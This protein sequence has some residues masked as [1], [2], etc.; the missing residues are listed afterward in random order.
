M[1]GISKIELE[2]STVKLEVNRQ[3][4]QYHLREL[5]QEFI[6]WQIQNRLMLFEML[7]EKKQPD[8]FSNHLPTL[9][10]MDPL[11][12]DFSVNAACKGIG[13]VP[14]DDELVK[15][16]AYIESTFGQIESTNFLNSVQKR[17]E[18]AM[19]LY[20]SPEKVN[21]RALGGLEIFEARSYKNMR[22]NPFV[23]LF[24]VGAAPHY[25]SYQ[26]NC[27]TEIVEPNQDFYKFLIAMR[28]L[29]EQATFHFQQPIY[30]F[31]VK[32]HVV[33]VIDKSL[34]VRGV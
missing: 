10:T 29:F 7:K 32:Y 17:I 2:N 11:R 19:V 1:N 25:K 9:L 15:M 26:I 28:N 34:R 31:A 6:A 5:P 12:T 30:P 33:E 23:S 4:V 22:N 8:F 3:K 24:F 14:H 20:G 18:G 21:P 13:L 27:I 16:T